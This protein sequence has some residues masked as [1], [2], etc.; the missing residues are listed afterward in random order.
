MS[1]NTEYVGVELSAVGVEDFKKSVQII[2]TVMKTFGEHADTF[3]RKAQIFDQSFENIRASAARAKQ[4]ATGART[5]A[6]EYGKA[7]A[8]FSTASTASSQKTTNAQSA[9]AKAT[10]SYLKRIQN[11]QFE[12]SRAIDRAYNIRLEAIRRADLN[13]KQSMLL[14]T[15]IQKQRAAARDQASKTFKAAE[16]ADST[17]RQGFINTIRKSQDAITDETRVLRTQIQQQVAARKR[18]IEEE[19]SF[20]KARQTAVAQE[21]QSAQSILTEQERISAAEFRLTQNAKRAYDARVAA[22]KDA[23]LNIVRELSQIRKAEQEYNQNLATISARTNS[24]RQ[25]F[26]EEGL[27][28]LKTFSAEVTKQNKIAIDKARENSQIYA[29][30]MR[31]AARIYKRES[32]LFLT[33]EEKMYGRRLQALRSENRFIRTTAQAAEG[34]RL[35]R[36]EIRDTVQSVDD[37]VAKISSASN[38]AVR[39]GSFGAFG[40]KR[41]TSESLNESEKGAASVGRFG[42]AIKNTQAALQKFTSVVFGYNRII[43]TVDQSTTITT[44]TFR[45]LIN[46]TDQTDNSFVGANNS[47]RKF[48]FSLRAVLPSLKLTINNI[49]NVHNESERA[50]QSAA[51][52]GNTLSTAIGTAIGFTVA[53]AFRQL[54]YQ[55]RIFTTTAL[56]N[57]AEIERL[58]L[59]FK[60]LA[61]REL[62]TTGLYEDLGA[63]QAE[64]TERAKELVEWNQ[65]LA[66]LSPFDQAD[67]A[68]AFKQAL[69]YGFVIEEAK[70]L[71]Q[72]VVDFTAAT[73][74]S[75][76][77]ANNIVL[78]LGQIR[79]AGKL[80]GQEVRQLVNQGIPV[81]QILSDAIGMTTAEVKKLSE[82]GLIPA[83][84]AIT[85]IVKSLR[86]DFAGAAAAQ[87]ETLSGLIN[88]LGDLAKISRRALFR[89]LSDQFIKPAGQEIVQFLQLEQTQAAFEKI[90]ASIANSLNV[91]YKTATRVIGSI[92]A[93]FDSIPDGALRVAKNILLVA[94]AVTVAGFAFGFLLPTLIAVQ[95]ALAA[96]ISPMSGVI[97]GIAALLTVWQTNL[98]GFRDATIQ[99]KNAIAEQ[100]S[101]LISFFGSV[102][103]AIYDWASDSA[104]GFSQ[105]RGQVRSVLEALLGDFAN[106]FQAMFKYG[107]N[108]FRSFSEGILSMA[109]TVR[110]AL[111]AIGQVIQYWLEPGSPP[112]LLPDL[113]EWGKGAADAYLE[114]WT[115]ADY[116]LFDSL[117]DGI[118]KALDRMD[119]ELDDE[120]MVGIQN[121]IARA[122]DQFNQ[123]GVDSTT[124]DQIAASAGE[125]SG[126]VRKIATAYFNA[127]DAARTY[128][129]LQAQLNETT[130]KY[131]KILAPIEATINRLSNQE[132]SFTDEQEIKDLQSVINNRYATEE[133]KRLAQI[134]LEKIQAEAQ[135]RNIEEE[136]DAS[137]SVIQQRLDEAEK[138]KNASD[139][140]LE[141]LKK[142]YDIQFD[143]L[144][145][146]NKAGGAAGAMAN[147]LDKGN[148]ALKKGKELADELAGALEGVGGLEDL[149]DPEALGLS[150]EVQEVLSKNP[151]QALKDRFEEVRAN[152]KATTDQIAALFSEGSPLY[153]ALAGFGTFVAFTLR[154]QI[155]G[156]AAALYGLLG[157]IGLLGVAAVLLGV[158]WKTNFRGIQQVAETVFPGIT[159]TIENA[160][161]QVTNSI[162][163]IRDAFRGGFQMETGGYDANDELRGAEGDIPG[164]NPEGGL[165]QF[166]DKLG[167]LTA[168]ITTKLTELR[169]QTTT[170]MASFASAFV[171]TEGEGPG[172]R[173]AAAINDPA[174]VT[175]FTTLETNIGTSIANLRAG[176]STRFAAIAEAVASG[177][178]A[179]IPTM[180]SVIDGTEVGNFTE[181]EASF[182]AAI[183]NFQS[184]VA[185]AWE[186][187][188]ISFQGLIDGFM[189]SST[190]QTIKANIEFVVD[191]LFGSIEFGDL[192]E[193]MANFRDSVSSAIEGITW[194]DLSTRFGGLI[195]AVQNALSGLDWGENLTTMFQNFVQNMV[196]ALALALALGGNIGDGNG[197]ETLKTMGE[198]IKALVGGIRQAIND[199]VT[200][201][202]DSITSI[203]WAVVGGSGG[204]TLAYGAVKFAEALINGILD[205]NW[206]QLLM[207]VLEFLGTLLSSLLLGLIGGL[208]AGIASIDFVGLF[209][210]FFNAV[211]E[212]FTG[213]IDGI[214][215]TVV[216]ATNWMISQVNKALPDRFDIPEIE[217]EASGNE[218]FRNSISK[219]VRIPVD[220]DTEKFQSN[221]QSAVDNVGMESFQSRLEEAAKNAGMAAQQGFS[222]GDAEAGPAI[223]F[224]AAT[225]NAVKEAEKAGTLYWENTKKSIESSIESDTTVPLSGLATKEQQAGAEMG[226]KVVEDINAQFELPANRE[227]MSAAAQAM[228]DGILSNPDLTEQQKADAQKV[229]DSLLN[230]VKAKAEIESPSKLFQREVG[231]PI[232]DG[233][234][235]AFTTPT[236]EMTQEDGPFNGFI[237]A[238]LENIM[239]LYEEFLIQMQDLTV[240]FNEAMVELF[241]VLNQSID[242]SFNNLRV[243]AE[244]HVRT[245]SFGIRFT[246]TAMSTA[247]LDTVR[248]MTSG[249]LS[250]LS[251][252]AVAVNSKDLKDKFVDA[253]ESIG[254]GLIDGI[255]EAIGGKDKESNINALA[256]ALVAVVKAATAQAKVEL[257]ISSPSGFTEAQVGG[258]LAEGISQGIFN[259]IGSVRASMKAAIN[260]AYE[261]LDAD[262]LGLSS[263]ISAN[264]ESSVGPIESSGIVY[265]ADKMVIAARIFTSA[266]G[267]FSPHSQQPAYAVVGGA[268]PRTI[269]VPSGQNVEYHLHMSVSQD[270]AE[271]VQ[272][273]YGVMKTLYG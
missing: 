151:F 158:A 156:A 204:F 172:A 20:V 177:K 53:N 122:V 222:S 216:G 24:L 55:M 116:E 180:I 4:A 72:T 166:A 175:A 39:I 208:A 202:V 62:V 16:Q 264:I 142:R 148:T 260:S 89:P 231:E 139:R 187:A 45:D 254:E 272:Q 104:Q 194:G 250:A 263:D 75:G 229:I 111:V 112:R 238:L 57:I 5:A 6:N 40:R 91:I 220:A 143:T 130:E 108:I 123:G 266:L 85:A 196:D 179:V 236:K 121:L 78:A 84:L 79:A 273:N 224:S 167:E 66:I 141:L 230:E 37:F 46:I 118:T 110:D 218:A 133:Q 87:Q 165:Q 131:E 93:V 95:G 155:A 63:A 188:K 203:D 47:V 137:L 81:W 205:I 257:Q 147:N 10:E 97:V 126:E 125:F 153:V 206:G 67:I 22:I 70:L 100:L 184:N 2:Q 29:T 127:A 1:G 32:D 157:P 234:L 265:L 219:G 144:D 73:G 90:G 80:T 129:K 185:V 262:P 31:A 162:Q 192:T 21:R 183:Q 209:K 145:I 237:T 50:A 58:E 69:A 42:T 115:L 132:Q 152:L 251:A 26:T 246:I 25:Q 241:S 18:Q 136:R 226:K 74:A 235:A 83:D 28:Q 190:G 113:T 135:K 43:N 212:L 248:D 138:E 11:L 105:F 168:K 41:N 94:S 178:G 217:F 17:A 160:R 64:A 169:D 134:K 71:T 38:A 270:R 30:S 107:A 109:R 114:G 227:S 120:Q 60:S 163:A 76:E 8:A 103:G 106:S 210:S 259:G 193:A 176:I 233:I 33:Q 149:M 186:N 171:F 221:V 173:L 102:A 255:V 244:N 117:K 213:A 199:F 27:R 9:A 35:W 189:N 228:M 232:R 44:N 92:R 170:L 14:Y 54:N 195:T 7:V 19:R 243:G 3:F 13:E 124:I 99:M 201:M 82:D 225:E 98:Y 101:Q 15:K 59:S 86:K 12:T 146:L 253:G 269:V 61:A 51:K 258:P 245:M 128:E 271:K 215:N 77:A 140:Q 261:G 191:F 249:V 267:Q 207:G 223:D 34:L 240:I 174:V 256:R 164:F 23:R 48:N 52:L 214:A 197:S 198:L 200:F 96:L 65:E 49:R 211:V 181:L 239:P 150:E 247:V 161:L 242:L 56:E 36:K 268:D 88:S 252:L 119:N 159:E 68:N 154:A 182:L